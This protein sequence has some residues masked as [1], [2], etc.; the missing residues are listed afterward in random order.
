ME[1]FNLYGDELQSLIEDM[2]RQMKLLQEKK[3]EFTASVK[4]DFNNSILHANGIIKEMN[5]GL[6][7]QSR[8]Q[9]AERMNQYKST[10]SSLQTRFQNICN[11]ANKNQLLSNSNGQLSEDLVNQQLIIQSKYVLS[12]S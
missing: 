3:I 2:E 7:S 11:E 5:L 6:D 8:K 4:N 9:V 12:Y 1:A 10:L